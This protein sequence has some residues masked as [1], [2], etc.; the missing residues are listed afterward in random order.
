MKPLLSQVDAPQHWSTRLPL[1]HGDP[2]GKQASHLQLVIGMFG[3][4]QLAHESLAQLLLLGVWSLLQGPHVLGACVGAGGGVGAGVAG[5]PA[6]ETSNVAYILLQPT[7]S[8]SCAE[9]HT[10]PHARQ[11]PKSMSLFYSFP[12][13]LMPRDSNPG[14]SVG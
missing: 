12:E 11:L 2:D 14:Q 7:A 9:Q 13:S 1:V 5:G 4:M 6:V 3:W 8:L 10:R